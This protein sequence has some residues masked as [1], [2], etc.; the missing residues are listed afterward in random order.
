MTPGKRHDDLEK[1][2][3]IIPREKLASIVQEVFNFHEENEQYVAS[4]LIALKMQKGGYHQEFAE[5]VRSALV[6]SAT[7]HVAKTFIDPLSQDIREYLL[8]KEVFPALRK[9]A[10][11]TGSFDVVHRLEN[12]LRKELCGEEEG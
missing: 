1:Q 9:A 3:K 2:N 6:A 4:L 8:E 5:L 12:E 11:S 10:A 7:E